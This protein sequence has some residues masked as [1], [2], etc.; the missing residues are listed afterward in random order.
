MTIRI[1]ADLLPPREAPG[2]AAW[3][4]RPKGDF[5][6]GIGAR[7]R[8]S[9]PFQEWMGRN[10]A[11]A[12][13]AVTAGVRAATDGLKADLRRAIIGGGLGD[14]LPNAVRSQVFPRRGVSL[15][16]AGWIFVK[17]KR[18]RE[19]IDAYATGIT[20]RARGKRFLAIPTAAG[21]GL[22]KARGGAAYLSGRYGLG[23]ET[24]LVVPR[25]RNKPWLI[26][27]N[28]RQG[29]G[30]RGGYRKPTAA[31]IKRR[32]FEEVVLFILVPEAKVRKR[33]TID[34]LAQRWADR[35]PGFIEQALP[36]L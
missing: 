13:G 7:A 4:D 33:F 12:A 21:R 23:I 26:V 19:I 15:S 28:L 29:R 30:K 2:F 32:D 18:T 3:R 35:V 14:R 11:V 1:A 16:A 9:G 31:A 34:G 6:T 17:G 25:D 22:I 5:L 8:I 20:I 27:A 36:E 10:V 24:R